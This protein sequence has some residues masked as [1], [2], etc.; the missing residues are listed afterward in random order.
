ML[1]TV[2][3]P[4][5]ELA[6]RPSPAFL[7]VERSVT[8][9]RWRE[10]QGDARIGLAI[11]QRLGLPEV[12]G[13][14]LAGR[15]IEPDA[16]ERHLA[17]TLRDFLP[18]PSSLADMDVAAERLARAIQTGE[19]IGVF[20]DYDVD[21]ATSSALLLR[22]LAA[23]GAPTLLHIP[24][25]RLE[26]YGPNLPALLAL[27]QAGAGVVVT[28]DCGT[29]AHVPLAEAVAAGLDIIVVDHH[30]AEPSLPP[31]LAV[32]NPNR[33]DE[34]GSLGTL[35][36]VGVTF[37]LVVAVNR[38]L[39]R[40]GWYMA[41]GVQG[42]RQG[43][44]Q[45]TGPDLLQWLD[46]VALGTVCDVVPLTGLNRALVAQ[47]IKVMAARRN[48]GL[49]ALA[50]AAAVSERLDAYHLGYVLGPRVN[51]GGRVGRADLGSR[52]LA[53]T[54]P[55]EAAALAATLEAF[56]A[57]R[58]SIEAEV[59]AQAI[60]AVEQAMA[61]RG[62]TPPSMIFAAGEG[63]HPGVIGIV[64]GR[65]KERFNRP[66]CVV[67]IENGIGKGSGRS[68][69]GID[70]GAA[71]IAARQAG[72]ALAG[73]GH[74][75]AAGFSVAIDQMTALESFLTGRFDAEALG[76]GQQPADLGLVPEL[77]VDGALSPAAATPELVET[78]AGLGPFGA[79]NAEPRF[80]L[81]QMRIL[82]AD[83]VG[84]NHVRCILA[85]PAGGDRVKAIAFRALDSELGVALL[86]A[87]G[88]P[89]HIAGHLRTDTW[90]GR[91]AV[92]LVIDDAAPVI[93][94][95]SALP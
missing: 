64:A 71:I 24:D 66:A 2:M 50:D 5:T 55:L 56:N 82:K 60:E 6:D 27:R 62:G 25:R 90:Q 93:A 48:P 1:A 65:L 29:T 59:L 86:R 3:P 92:Q 40:A 61:A 78:L 77:G 85:S 41:D 7:G 21:G 10:R 47:G 11:A 34:D 91:T 33:L 87:G 52:L 36:A 45:G 32:V 13:R 14:V 35:A 75:M 42:A 26:G 9:K 44:G 79:G 70:L 22:F 89:M 68:V 67:A 81:P 39:R 69:P 88:L 19:T 80:V 49:A 73:G 63:W 74:R 76:D 31:V 58:R 83:V 84:Q 53:T 57:D 72:L 18:D 28:V 94:V 20:G 12:V 4:L 15:G 30:A 51:A 23:V 17:P 95:E 54:D 38:A 8:G 46:L 43:T 16:V 37:L